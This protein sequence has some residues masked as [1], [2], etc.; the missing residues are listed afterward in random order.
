[1]A[2]RLL[3][4]PLFSSTYTKAALMCILGI[5]RYFLLVAFLFLP[6][7][8]F[9]VQAQQRENEYTVYGTF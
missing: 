3:A 5:L 2:R 4:I 8:V 1:M 9:N 7:F 6:A